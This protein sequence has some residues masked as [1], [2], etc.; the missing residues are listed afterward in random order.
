MGKTHPDPLV[1]LEPLDGRERIMD[2]LLSRFSWPVEEEFMRDS[3][4]VVTDPARKKHVIL[5]PREN[6]RE[7]PPFTR[8]LHEMGHALLAETAHQQFSR[9]FFVRGTDPA[10]RNTY[11]AV[12]DAAL[13][14]YVQELLMGIAPQIQGDDIDGRFRQTTR[15]LREGAALPGVEFTMDAGLALASFERLRGLAV[16]TQGR[17]HT[18]K[19]AFLHAAPDKPSLFTLQ[20]LVRRLVEAF[21]AH[22]ASL[23][24]EKGFEHWRITPLK[25]D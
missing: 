8:Y 16:K 5:W 21:G 6:S 17:L 4:E 13:D 14:W 20:S 1:G 19:E 18:V 25:R 11:S 24:R 15:M 2:A 9:P 10:I 23:K 22:T 3:F 7:A 12:F